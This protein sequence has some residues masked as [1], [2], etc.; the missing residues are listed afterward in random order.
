[1]TRPLSL[2]L[3]LLPATASAA[4]PAVT[5]VAYHPDGRSVAFARKGSVEVFDAAGVGQE[6]MAV[7]GPVTALAYA[8]QGNWLAVATAEPGQEGRVSLVAV[9]PGGRLEPG[10]GGPF[11]THKDAIYA[12]AFSPDGRALATAGYDRVI[13]L[14]EVP[15]SPGGKRDERERGPRLTL[16][17]HSDAVYGLAFS[18]D[19]KLLA[20][21]SADRALKVWDAATGK[22]LYT[23]ADAT[24]WLY[25]V[26]WSPDKKHLAAAGVDKSIRVWEADAEGARLV[27]SC[28]AHE[29]PVL[30]LAYAKDGKTLYSAG[31]D[32]VVKSWDAAKLT[33]IKVYDAQP[34]SILDIALRPDGKQFSL[35]RFD[36]AGLLIDSA[37]GKVVAQPL[38]EKEKPKPAPPP[39]PVPPSVTKLTPNG[40]PRGKTTRVVVS[41]ANLDR[42]KAVTASSPE[43]KVKVAGVKAG[44]LALEVTVGDAARIGAAQLTFEG[45]G[46][47]SAPV[48]LAIDRFAAVPEAGTTDSAHAAMPVALPATVVGTIDRAGDV[49]Y[50]RFSAKPGDQVGVQVVGGEL[51][52]KLDPA[53]AITDAAGN[54]LA[55]GGTSLGFVVRQPGTYAV[56]VRD[57]EFRGGGGFHYRLHV[58]PAPVVTGVF[59][60][61]AQ[62]GRTTSVHV[63]G[64]NLG[65]GSVTAKVTVPADAKP[66]SKVPVPLGRQ[67]VGSPTVVVSE[68]PSVVIDPAA[69][70]DLRVPG[71]ADGI[72]TKPNEAQAARFHA[73]KGERLLVEVL[74]QRAG[75]PVD[76]VVEILD[77]A[78]KPVPLAVLRCAAKTSVTFRDHDSRGAGIRLDAWNE[79][80]VDDYLYVNGEVVRILALP[81]GPDD[82]A[83]FYQSA[84]QRLAFFGTSPTH[85]AFGE[86]MFKVEAHPPGSK[87][88]PNGMPLFQLNYRN[89]DG[90]PGYGK[91]SA[92]FFDPP[93]DGT[94]QVRVTDARGASGPAHAF[95]V[96]VRPPRPDFTV[97]ASVAGPQLLKGGSVPVNVTVGRIDGF[98]GPVSVSVKSLPAGFSAAPTTV[99]SGHETATLAL[100]GSP[101]A[102]L[103]K[104]PGAVLVASAT[105]GGKEVVREVPLNLPAKLAGGDILTAVREPSVVIEPGKESRFTVDIK[106]QGKFAG[107]VPLEV[108]NLPHGVRVLHVG[109]N[110][111]LVTE[112]ETSREVVLFAEPWVKPMSR[113]ILVTSR[114]EGVG[115]EFGAKPLVLEVK[116]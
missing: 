52:S 108:R 91:D 7:R 87:F 81:K 4:P 88:P 9:Q 22:R 106:R 79:L 86:A 100:F 95:R 94:Y 28:F 77:A 47:K 43:V 111:I 19:G 20:S 31:E 104:Q 37:S 66:G 73:K 116:K 92:L 80:A 112:R 11:V 74:A 70:A 76:P 26:A 71:S 24:D 83:Q 59:P 2:A 99:E 12:L 103:P 49:D 25:A 18:P 68:F 46:G 27:G 32:R 63:T 35:A 23:L 98:D 48:T 56:S 5:A 38:P 101:E 44:E 93:A 61:A 69:G 16:K 55:E 65:S 36:G 89:D 75:S 40:A 97:T 64:V 62:R 6:G 82:D 41:G 8:P 3:L 78:G 54:V 21:A 13:H 39:K 105:I 42:V 45:D 110:G 1:M 15:D 33:E 29:K 14:W 50:F 84:G 10:K 60:L 67:A 115:G 58:G 53:L 72:L 30:R 34:D 96:T 57:R 17:D 114:R 102:E 85:H 107:R 90:G 113:P 51:G 109:L